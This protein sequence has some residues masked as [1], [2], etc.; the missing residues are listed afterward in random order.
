[1]TVGSPFGERGRT[2]LCATSYRWW[3]G[4][5]NLDEN[6]LV[7]FCLFISWNVIDVFENQ[8]VICH[9]PK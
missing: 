8:L 4:T 7:S 6:Q 2:A 9:S 5:A 1:M 3:G